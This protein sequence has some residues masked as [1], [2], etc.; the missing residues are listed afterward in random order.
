[1]PSTLN[2]AD[3]E[4]PLF[5]KIMLLT[6][7]RLDFRQVNKVIQKKCNYISGKEKKVRVVRD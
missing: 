4:Y 7:K 1:M 6:S 5:N 3:S 2:T